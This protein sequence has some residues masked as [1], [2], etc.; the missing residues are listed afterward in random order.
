MV[1]RFYVEGPLAD[2]ASTVDL[3]PAVVHQ[4]VAVLRMRVGDAVVIFDESGRE[5][6]GVLAEV[7]RHG[8]R[9]RLQ[10]VTVP[11]REAVRRVTLCQALLKADKMEWVL[12]KGTE[13]GVARFEPLLTERVVAAKREA[14]E[15]WRRILVEAT[16][17]CG[18]TRVPELVQPV[19]LQ[20]ALGGAATQVVCWE[21]EHERALAA[22]L[23]VDRPS[24]LRLF[25]GPEGGFSEREANLA[26][27]RDAVTVSLGPRILRAETAAVAASALALLAP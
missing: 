10:G 5:W 16:E 2:G 27:E 20:E 22:W 1:Q 15:R 3:P 21:G 14:P 8:A 23:A 7:T 6:E 18:R 25:I 12:Q 24:E 19:P 11:Q 26:R 13:L 17:Q 4:V 9:V